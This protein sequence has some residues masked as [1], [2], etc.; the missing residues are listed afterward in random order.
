ML[1]HAASFW[2]IPGQVPP[3]DLDLDLITVPTD[4]DSAR[5]CAE[6]YTDEFSKF[7]NRFKILEAKFVV[8]IHEWALGLTQVTDSNFSNYLRHLPT[9]DAEEWMSARGTKKLMALRRMG[10][11]IFG[12][13]NEIQDA[14]ADRRAEIERREIEGIVVEVDSEPVTWQERSIDETWEVAFTD[15]NKLFV[16]SSR[17]EHTMEFCRML[18]VPYVEPLREYWEPIVVYHFGRSVEELAD[19]A[20][21]PL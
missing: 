21:L 10:E 20:I 13:L 11:I 8:Q 16:H 6:Y 19:R 9:S 3:T 5:V 2:F 1:K 15:L 14:V 7:I 17:W 4:L 12:V 18:L